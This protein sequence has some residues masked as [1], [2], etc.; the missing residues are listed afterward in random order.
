MRLPLVRLRGGA[1]AAATVKKVLRSSPT[2][3][4]HRL[5]IALV[6]ADIEASR[7]RDM[8]SRCN[9]ALLCMR[10]FALGGRVTF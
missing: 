5:S 2:S 9:Q 3:Y 10:S 4:V 7:G 1:A 8:G 6:R